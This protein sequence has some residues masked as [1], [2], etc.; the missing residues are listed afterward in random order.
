MSRKWSVL[1]RQFFQS[2]I[3]HLASPS[4]HRHSLLPLS[5]R[6]PQ[7]LNLMRNPPLLVNPTPS[8]AL[9]RY[10]SQS[11]FRSLFSALRYH[12]LLRR[13]RANLHSKRPPLY[14]R[15]LVPPLRR[16]NLYTPLYINQTATLRP[17]TRPMLTTNDQPRLKQMQRTA[18][19]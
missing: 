10:L 11:L 18:A 15:Y 16:D 3:L 8:R 7:S 6:L 9:P 13:T 17:I 19:L 2:K 14:L 4:F 1:R 12:P 5:S